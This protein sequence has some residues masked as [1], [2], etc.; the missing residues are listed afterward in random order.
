[1]KFAFRIFLFLA[2]LSSLSAWSAE[3]T[4]APAG[5]VQDKAV[6]ESASPL[7]GTTS[8]ESQ[9]LQTAIERIRETKIE[10]RRNW[11]ITNP[12]APLPRPP[13]AD[14]SDTTTAVLPV[15]GAES[16]TLTADQLAVLRTLTNLPADEAALLGAALQKAGY[17]DEAF[18]FFE[19]AMRVCQGAEQAYFLL[20]MAHCKRSGDPEA[21]QTLYRR[22][23]AEFADT[24][25]APL[26]EAYDSMLE[27][28][29][30]HRPQD[31]IRG[32]A[33]GSGNGGTLPPPA[34]KSS[35]AGGAVSRQ[36]ARGGR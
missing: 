27:F 22:V 20:Q 32:A 33:S 30:T 6:R 35:P 25:W 1:M 15:A 8:A 28:T 4:S 3:P 24:P 26:A 2:V 7:G 16:G 34:A 5:G 14:D 36:T 10:P 31:V 17:L 23:A 21:A 11:P 29:K 19:Q 18:R 12:P 13:E 9:R